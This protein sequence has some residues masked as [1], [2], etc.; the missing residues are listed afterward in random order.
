MRCEGGDCRD[1]IGI[2]R[3]VGGYSGDL[4]GKLS[5]GV[6]AVEGE[7]DDG[8]E[9]SCIFSFSFSFFFGWGDDFF[10]SDLSGSGYVCNG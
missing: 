2:S 8:A 7:D 6:L 3:V 5:F 9:K 1:L 4:V 10:P